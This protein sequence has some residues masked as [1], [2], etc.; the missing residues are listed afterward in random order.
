[1]K[2]IKVTA[3]KIIIKMVKTGDKLT[4]TELEKHKQYIRECKKNR[5]NQIDNY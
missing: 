5:W 1:M 3:P 4:K 2:K